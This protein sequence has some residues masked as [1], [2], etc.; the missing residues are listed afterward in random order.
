MSFRP[1]QLHSLQLL[2]YNFKTEFKG[3]DLRKVV[4]EVLRI[5]K[6]QSRFQRDS[7]NV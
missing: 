6:G 4:N 5:S 1:L 7:K 2:V 3:M